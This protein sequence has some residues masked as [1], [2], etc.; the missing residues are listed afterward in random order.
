VANALLLRPLA[1]RDPDRLVLINSH[2]KSANISQGP[3]SFTRFEQVE[4]RNRSFSGV[5]AFAAE[6][7]NLTGRG[8]PSRFSRRA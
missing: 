6:I 4:S 1:Y 2:R 5:A 8:D 7:F 3:L